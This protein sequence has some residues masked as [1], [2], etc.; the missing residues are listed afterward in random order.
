MTICRRTDTPVI[1][2]SHPTNEHGLLIDG[3]SNMMP[4]RLDGDCMPKVLI[5]NDDLSNSEKSDN[6]YVYEEDFMINAK[7]SLKFVKD[8]SIFY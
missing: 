3:E 1:E 2:V 5:D 8:K 4:L 7:R 6:D